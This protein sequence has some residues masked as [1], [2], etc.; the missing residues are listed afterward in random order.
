MGSNKLFTTKKTAG[1]AVDTTSLLVSAKNQHKKISKAPHSFHFGE[2]SKQTSTSKQDPSIGRKV[3]VK[4]T[5][6][7]PRSIDTEELTESIGS[8]R[9]CGSKDYRRTTSPLSDEE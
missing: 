2:Q 6:K 1:Q 5:R 8:W 4:E 3:S 7:S 9:S